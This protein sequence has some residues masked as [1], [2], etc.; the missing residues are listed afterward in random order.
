[1]YNGIEGMELLMGVCVLLIATAYQEIPSVND[2]VGEI[3][4]KH[5]EDT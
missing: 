5:A 2:A 3:R 4:E 1:V